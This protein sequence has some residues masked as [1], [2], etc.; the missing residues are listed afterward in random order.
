MSKYDPTTNGGE[1]RT[2]TRAI[3]IRTP[4]D[5]AYTVEILE[6]E[7]IREAGNGERVINDQA[8]RISA[9]DSTDERAA[10]FPL[11]SPETDQPTGENATGAEFMAMVYSYVRAKQAERDEAE[12]EG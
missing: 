5:A 11:L 10:V 6:Q 3:N 7:V 4:H 1:T 12:S 9:T 8:G 2:R